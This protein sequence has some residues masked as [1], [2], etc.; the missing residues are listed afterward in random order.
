MLE[1]LATNNFGDTRD[2]GAAGLAG[3]IALLFI[4]LLAV[5]LVFL[6]RSMGRHLRNLP[7]EFP[8]ELPNEPPKDHGQ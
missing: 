1:I 5:A 4:V 8:R 3:P 6:I 7:A 2:P